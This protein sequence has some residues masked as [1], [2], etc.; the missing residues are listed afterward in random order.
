MIKSAFI[1]A[2]SYSGQNYPNKSDRIVP[3]L[4]ISSS[5]SLFNIALLLT[6]SNCNIMSV[7]GT[8]L[9][10]L[11]T[12]QLVKWPVAKDHIKSSLKRFI[13]TVQMYGGIKGFLF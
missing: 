3:P 11:A 4:L 2:Q 8:S 13:N 7:F 12:N 10:F 9:Q 5:R 1:L 6:K